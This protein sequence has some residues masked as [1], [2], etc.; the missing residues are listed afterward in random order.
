MKAEPDFI[1]KKNVEA[2]VPDMQEVEACAVKSVEDMEIEKE[3]FLRSEADSPTEIP[4][5]LPINGPSTLLTSPSTTSFFQSSK[6]KK[7][8]PEFKD[9]FR[10]ALDRLSPQSFL[11]KVTLYDERRDGDWDI[12]LSISSA[13][14]VCFSIFFA[15]L[16][17]AMLIYWLLSQGVGVFIFSML[18]IGG[19]FTWLPK[20]VSRRVKMFTSL[21]KYR[22]DTKNR[23]ENNEQIEKFADKKLQESSLWQSRAFLDLKH[24]EEILKDKQICFTDVVW[25][26]TLTGTIFAILEGLGKAIGLSEVINPM[27]IAMYDLLTILG[28][29]MIIVSLSGGVF[30]ILK[31]LNEALSGFIKRDDML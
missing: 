8:K 19:F 25:L 17:G 28:G 31:K 14:W 20:I 24:E 5:E 1:G 9:R 3:G 27:H 12:L 6:K 18:F 13:L 22:Y 16:P 11:K 21:K 10:I 15:C 29:F 7:Y 2:Y 4:T 30:W 23:R 26:S